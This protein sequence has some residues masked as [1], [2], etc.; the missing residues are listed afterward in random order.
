MGQCAS[1]LDGNVK[2]VLTRF[3]AVAGYPGDTKISREL[4][5]IATAHTPD[6]DCA[7]YT[8]AIMDLGATCCVRR[9]PDCPTCPMADQCAAYA[10]NEVEAF[11]ASKPKKAKPVRRSRFFVVTLPNSAAL[12]EQKP[13]NGLWGG[14]WTPPERAEDQSIETFLAELGLDTRDLHAQH[15]APEFRHTFTH[16]HL[17]IAPVYLKLTRQPMLIENNPTLRWVDPLNLDQANDR[18]GLSAPAVKLLASLQE[19]FQS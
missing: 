11:P 3:H 10:M 7:T 4:W 16:F 18:I 6:Q 8:Q 5:D 9:R 17:E 2:R 14:L 1:I 12:L 19:P 13:M 15:I